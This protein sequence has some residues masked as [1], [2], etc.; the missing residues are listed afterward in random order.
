M[1]N[2]SLGN[3]KIIGMGNHRNVYQ[4]PDNEKYVIKHAYNHYSNSLDGN[5]NYIEIK[6]WET[7]KFDKRISKYFA[8]IIDY[9][10]DYNFL[11]M[12][13]VAPIYDDILIKSIQKYIPIELLEDTHRI[14]NCGIIN[15]N[16]LLI[17]YGFRT[18]INFVK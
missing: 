3:L 8:P 2:Y 18:N 5:S 9:S 16:I 10:N 14:E 11:I 1:E 17:D 15:N 4:H 7:V 13:K 6:V 12:E